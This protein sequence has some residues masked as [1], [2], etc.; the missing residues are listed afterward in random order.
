MGRKVSIIAG[1]SRYQNHPSGSAIE[2]DGLRLPVVSLERPWS[3]ELSVMVGLELPYSRSMCLGNAAVKPR[4]HWSHQ[5]S[6][7]L[8]CSMV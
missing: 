1:G 6:G 2:H 4:W 8:C 7:Q 5:N 3:A